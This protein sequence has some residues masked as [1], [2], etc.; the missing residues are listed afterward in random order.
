LLVEVRV[1]GQVTPVTVVTTHLNSRPA[2][3]VNDA[4]S[5]QAYSR[6]VATLSAFIASN[7]S[8][9]SPLIVA[10]DFNA[11]SPARRALLANARLV[12][13]LSET[14]P[15]A[16]SA[17]DIVRS[18]TYLTGQLGEEAAYIARR[19]RDWQFFGDGTSWSLRPA[20]IEIPFG[21]EKDGSSLSDHL[22]FVIDFQAAARAAG[23]VTPDSITKV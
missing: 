17:L 11:S 22:G 4:R 10:G 13:G 5:L 9:A 19:G 15:S 8:P 12:S 3:G 2:S 14:V 18:S 7:R 23:S 6:Q 1:P 20:A 16:Q 21:I